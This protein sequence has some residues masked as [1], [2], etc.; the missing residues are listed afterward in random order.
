MKTREE[1]SMDVGK[2]AICGAL[3][4][5]AVGVMVAIFSKRRQ[6][7]SQSERAARPEGMRAMRSAEGGGLS[8]GG[9]AGGGMS[10]GGG[11]GGGMSGGGGAGGGAGGGGLSS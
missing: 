9:G 7:E 6:V 5:A 8:G 10:G 2:A 1:S 11:A 3:T 4:G